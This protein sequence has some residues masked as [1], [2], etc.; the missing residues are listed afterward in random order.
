MPPKAIALSRY[1]M[2]DPLEI[3]DRSDGGHVRDIATVRLI[4]AWGN[5]LKER[6]AQD[7]DNRILPQTIASRNRVRMEINSRVE[8]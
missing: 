7:L 2:S 6:I 3:G 1:N 5:F 8:P 4:C